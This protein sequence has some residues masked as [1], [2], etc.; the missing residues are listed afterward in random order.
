MLLYIIKKLCLKKIKILLEDLKKV[1]PEK[2]ENYLEKIVSMAASEFEIFECAL[3]VAIKDIKANKYVIMKNN[4]VIRI[5]LC[6]N[7][8]V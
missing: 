8:V 3:Y 2:L 1:A 6:F 5:L 7:H 4:L